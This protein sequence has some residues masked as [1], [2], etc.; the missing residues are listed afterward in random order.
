MV[1]FPAGRHSRT[2]GTGA[3]V[4][5]APAARCAGRVPVTCA[6]GAPKVPV[7]GVPWPAATAVSA[8]SSTTYSAAATLLLP[9]LTSLRSAVIE[10][11]ERPSDVDGVTVAWLT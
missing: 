10:T 6:V 7:I 4:Q 1:C 3:S 8:S 2:T 5:A 9:D 11:S